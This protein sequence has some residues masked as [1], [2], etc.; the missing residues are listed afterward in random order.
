[1][2]SVSIWRKVWCET[3][4]AKQWWDNQNYPIYIDLENKHQ[5]KVENVWVDI[6]D[7]K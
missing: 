4:G 7:F 2:G 1:M 6:I 5:E 3:G